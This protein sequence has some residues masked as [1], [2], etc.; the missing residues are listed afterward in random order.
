MF[1]FA[2]QCGEVYDPGATDPLASSSVS[3]QTESVGHPSVTIDATSRSSDADRLNNPYSVHP[4]D[5]YEVVSGAVGSTD[6]AFR[7]SVDHSGEWSELC[8]ASVSIDNNMRPASHVSPNSPSCME[9][10]ELKTELHKV[11][12]ALVLIAC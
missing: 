6:L 9:L 4:S 10:N 1:F 7:F 12:I 8:G 3:K 2:F 11:R 5:T